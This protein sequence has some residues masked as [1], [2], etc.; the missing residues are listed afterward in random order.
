MGATGAAAEP[1]GVV[2]RASEL[3]RCV[4][5]AAVAAVVAVTVAAVGDEVDSASVVGDC[6]SISVYR[7]TCTA[8]STVLISPLSRASNTH[9]VL[10][11]TLRPAEPPLEA[12]RLA[13]DDDDLVLSVNHLQLTCDKH[14]SLSERLR[15]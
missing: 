2:E 15:E 13:T 7:L 1:A 10:V 11:R 5:V 6:R 9:C 3:S 14:I 8:A 4:I 12:P